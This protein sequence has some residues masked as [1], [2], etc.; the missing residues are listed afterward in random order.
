[1]GG[2]NR[3]RRESIKHICT[4]RIITHDTE[5]KVK[6]SLPREPTVG[7][8]N[9]QADRMSLTVRARILNTVCHR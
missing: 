7:P 9:S 1:M 6:E 4:Y 3:S 5:M 8:K 2:L